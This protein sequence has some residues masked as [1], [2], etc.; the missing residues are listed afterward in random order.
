M[1]S[2]HQTFNGQAA[3]VDDLRLEAVRAHKRAATAA[4]NGDPIIQERSTLRAA[5]LRRQA[6]VLAARIGYRE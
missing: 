6:D 5:A 4:D 2:W 1:Y 3:L